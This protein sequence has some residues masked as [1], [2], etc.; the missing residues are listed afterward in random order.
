L[1]SYPL[2][3]FWVPGLPI[4]WVIAVGSVLMWLSFDAVLGVAI[5]ARILAILAFAIAA[6]AFF[7]YPVGIEI[8]EENI[9]VVFLFGISTRI[10]SRDLEWHVQSAGLVL[11]AKRLNGRYLSLLNKFSLILPL[12]GDGDEL[13]CRLKEH[14][15]DV[16]PPPG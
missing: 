13:V 9:R 15:N 2:R 16:A 11:V 12:L 6:A 1:Y 3:G 7:A 10:A 14:G 5:L 4:A 8:E